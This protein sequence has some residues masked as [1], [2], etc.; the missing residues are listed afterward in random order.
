MANSD[1]PMK[2][3]GNV[4]VI[5]TP[6]VRAAQEYARAHADDMTY[7]HVMR[8]WLFSVAISNKVESTYGSVDLEAQALSAILHDLGWDNTGELVSTDKRFEVD[9][10]IAARNW[11]HEQVKKGIAKDWDE[12]RIQLVWDAIALH[13]TTSINQYKE[14]VVALVGFGIA[15]DFRGPES[16]P[17][18]TLTWDEYNAIKTEF[19]RHNLGLG[20]REKIC[21]LVTLKPETTYGTIPT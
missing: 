4:T 19:P 12:H 9:G 16:D 15:A 10:A 6:L 21:A 17:T 11:I 14:P 5:D 20:V 1:L 3:L 2:L 7:N 18:K 8:S 13:S